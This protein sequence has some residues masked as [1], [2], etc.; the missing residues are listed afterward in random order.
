MMQ[1]Q[2]T[3][4]RNTQKTKRAFGNYEYDSRNE[5]LQGLEDTVEQTKYREPKEIR[6]PSKEVNR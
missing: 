4:K 6:G 1:E 2:H 5:M 3:A